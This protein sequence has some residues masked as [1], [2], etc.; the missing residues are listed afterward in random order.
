[1]R[2]VVGH[3][4][5]AAAQLTA[6]AGL[7]Q[8]EDPAL[9]GGDG[10]HSLRGV[11]LE[12]GVLAQLGAVVGGH[13][14]RLVPHPQQL[15]VRVEGEGRDAHPA[16][17]QHV[18]QGAELVVSLVLLHHPG[19]R[20]RLELPE[21]AGVVGLLHVGVIL[22]ALARVQALGVKMSIGGSVVRRPILFHLERKNK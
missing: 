8:G 6:E 7:G 21:G 5:N 20:P 4:G 9:E 3:H 16:V 2:G 22:P 13:V 1:M 12:A 18:A 14:A 10:P 15:L 11:H 19:P 17:P